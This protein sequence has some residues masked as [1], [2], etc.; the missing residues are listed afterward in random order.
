MN[1]YGND[2]I[3]DQVIGSAYQVVRY[4]AANMGLLIELSNSMGDIQPVLEGL[5]SVIDNMPALLE[6]QGNISDLLELHS[7]LTELLV[8][9]NNLSILSNIHDYLDDIQIIA[10]NLDILSSNV[11]L[12]SSN[13]EALRRSYAEAGLNL[14]DG[15]FEA[16]G[17][18]VNVNDVLLQKSTGIAYA[19]TG[20]FPK[21]VAPETDPAL[22]ESGFIPRSAITLRGE[23]SSYRLASFTSVSDMISGT[24]HGGVV[25]TLT[26][27]DECSTGATRWRIGA[28]ASG[29]SVG[30]GLY[31][32]PLTSICLD[33]YALSSSVDCSAALQAILNMA[34]AFGIGRVYSKGGKTYKLENTVDFRG[35]KAI[36]FDF[37]WS[38]LIDNVQGFIPASA[39]R[40]KQTFILYNCNGSKVRCINWMVSPTRASNGSSIVPDVLVWLGGQYLGAEITT[41]VQVTDIVFQQTMLGNCLIGVLGELR[42]CK[43]RNI[44]VYGNA[45]YGINFEYGHQPSDPETDPTL[46]NGLHPYNCTVEN[47]NGYDL[48]NCQ[49]FLRVAGCYSIKFKN[50]NGYNV[51]SFIYCYGG[52]RNISRVSESVRFVNCKSKLDENVLPLNYAVWIVIVNKDGSTD[53]NLPSWTN[54]DHQFVFDNCE[55]WNGTGANSACLRF[56]GN[57]GATVFNNCLFKRSYYGANIMPSSNP[58]YRSRFS[59]VFNDC[60]FD[61]NYQDMYINGVDGVKIRGGKM[62]RQPSTSTLPQI[63]IGAVDNANYTTIEDLFVG[64]QTRQNFALDVVSG[65]GTMLRNNRFEMY[66]VGHTA[67]K[68]AELLHGDGNNSTNGILISTANTAKRIR[69]EPSTGFKET[70]GLAGP[71]LDYQVADKWLI[72]SALTTNNCINARDGDE[73]IFRGATGGAS[74]TITHGAGGT[75]QYANK[76]VTSDTVTGSTFAKRYVYQA[77]TWYEM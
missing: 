52:D 4:V 3:V 45:S 72:N 54:Y 39:N 16:G 32:E 49:G 38:V 7:H 51:K 11:A 2:M 29:V 17:T 62:K 9:C 57:Q 23:V 8:I 71:T 10:D 68:S 67:I 30:G 31:A 12:L 40:A 47:F 25:I 64:E 44:D 22:I 77:G 1:P 18:L 59:L 55:F 14:V 69:G 70:T 43:V 75:G 41:N 6:I 13:R 5:H 19:W 74:L 28:N 36:D 24:T 15:S 20:T 37:G 33:D 53:E 61:Q 76:S 65:A 26:S 66:S 27:G 21:V 58:T 73:L 50:C 34:S 60:I 46:T 48:L 42:G 63:S 35:L 56:V